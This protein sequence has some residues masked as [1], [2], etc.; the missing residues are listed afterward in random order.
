MAPDNPIFRA[1]LALLD[2]GPVAL[3]DLPENLQA[4]F[5][6]ARKD[7]RLQG[8]RITVIEHSMYVYQPQDRFRAYYLALAH[9]V[10]NGRRAASAFLA[11]GEY[12]Y[13]YN[14]MI[15]LLYAGGEW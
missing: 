8:F 1:V 6:M 15:I 11:R 14:G 10:K 4:G 13:H 5:R 9:G 12:K 7:G 2:Q 3:Q